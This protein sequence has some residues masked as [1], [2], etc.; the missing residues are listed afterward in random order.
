MAGPLAYQTSRLQ[1]T[2][3]LGA[4]CQGRTSNIYKSRKGKYSHFSQFL[5]TEICCKCPHKRVWSMWC[6]SWCDHQASFMPPSGRDKSSWFRSLVPALRRLPLDRAPWASV[7]ARPPG[8][9][10]RHKETYTRERVATARMVEAAQYQSRGKLHLAW[11][12]CLERKLLQHDFSSQ[13]KF[14]LHVVPL[15][16]CRF[17]TN[18]SSTWDSTRYGWVSVGKLSSAG[19]KAP[20][21][22]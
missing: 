2:Q 20:S 19:F 13:R 15:A 5:H 12:T 21:Q 6:S 17:T 22:V 16:K 7:E 3:G 9:W 4:R 1:P 8:A 11:H 10:S 14:P 18:F